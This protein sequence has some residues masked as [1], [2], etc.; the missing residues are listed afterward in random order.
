LQCAALQ[1]LD[2][3]VVIGGVIVPRLVFGSTTQPP[4]VLLADAPGAT[5]LFHGG[6]I[7]YT[8]ANKIGAVGVPAALIE[9]HTAVSRE[10][11]EA[12]ARGGIARRPVDRAI[13]IT[14][15]TGPEPENC[16]EVDRANAG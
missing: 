7:V 12:M 15:V 10:V 2:V 11:T 14:G 5:D 16:R 3:A 9:A 1:R 8:K 6:F 13:S 4:G